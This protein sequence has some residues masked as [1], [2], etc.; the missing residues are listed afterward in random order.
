[1]VK[2]FPKDSCNLSDSSIYKALIRE[3][4]IAANQKLQEIQGAADEFARQ[5][6]I[7]KLR[8]AE[9]EHEKLKLEFE[10]EASDRVDNILSYVELSAAENE[11]NFTSG[12]DGLLVK[13]FKFFNFMDS[14][15][16][17]ETDPQVYGMVKDR[18]EKETWLAAIIKFLRDKF[19]KLIK[20]IFSRDL[21]FREQID[22]EIGKLFE[23]LFGDSLSQEEEAAILERLE[24]LRNLKLK[25]QMFVA[26]SVI[27]V[28]IELFSVELTAS[29][30]TTKEEGKEKT[31][32]KE[33]EATKEVHEIMEI[34]LD[35][36]G[37][38]QIVVSSYLLDFSSGV[39]RPITL[40]KQEL[41]LLPKPLANLVHRVQEYATSKENSWVKETK[42]NENKQA[43]QPA[44][45]PN[46][47]ARPT[48][49][50]G[51]VPGT[52]GVKFCF[53]SYGES[54]NFNTR[55][56]NANVNS[57]NGKKPESNNKQENKFA[58][59]ERKLLNNDV[60]SIN[61]EGGKSTNGQKADSSYAKLATKAA[62]RNARKKCAEASTKH[63]YPID[64]FQVPSETNGK[65]HASAEREPKPKQSSVN[66]AQPTGECRDVKINN[67]VE[68]IGKTQKEA[69]SRSR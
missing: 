38:Y 28:F 47:A 27:T 40:T 55:R 9:I 15:L 44:Q 42:V 43:K 56:S 29:V 10:Q 60:N 48:K 7:N 30:E 67:H 14:E 53:K 19:N 11:E 5:A 24:A 17:V 49:E 46:V 54:I 58:G 18:E 41:D 61:K 25:L 22:K 63:D 34:K 33:K 23:R 3:E 16:G 13:L 39:A 8:Q 64:H 2:D 68:S 65:S 31:S 36:K 57:V 26:G 45:K 20:A 51:K 69:L 35:T 59:S 1:M 32:A 21:S 4:D 6:I 66:N 50:P 12:I 37:R 62:E 52:S